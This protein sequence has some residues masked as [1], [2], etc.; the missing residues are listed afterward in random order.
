MNVINI[1]FGQHELY[2]IFFLQL[3]LLVPSPLV[4]LGLWKSRNLRD[5]ST[6]LF[7]PIWINH[8]LLLHVPYFLWT[9]SVSSSLHSLFKNLILLAWLYHTRLILWRRKLTYMLLFKYFLMW[10]WFSFSIIFIFEGLNHLNLIF[11]LN[12]KIVTLSRGIKGLLLNV[13]ELLFVCEAFNKIYVV[14]RWEFVFYIYIAW[15]VYCVSST[16]LEFSFLDTCKVHVYL[17]AHIFLASELI[18]FCYYSI[19]ITGLQLHIFNERDSAILFKG[20]LYHFGFLRLRQ[21]L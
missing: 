17:V 6:C 4:Y 20:V 11:Q 7:R 5:L 16:L 12:L 10:L 21:L 15:S 19:V 18:F 8:Q 2:L 9:L 14:W 1:R 3:V 13:V